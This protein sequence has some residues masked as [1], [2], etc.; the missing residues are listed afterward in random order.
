MPSASELRILSQ[1]S[2]QPDLNRFPNYVYE[3]GAG[4][5]S[6]IYHAE[7]GINGDHIDFQGRKGEWV[8]TPLSIRAGQNTKNQSPSSSNGHSTC[9]ASKASGNVYGAAK[10]ATLVVVKLPDWTA[11]AMQEILEVIVYHISTNKGG[12]RAVVNIS[13]GSLERYSDFSSIKKD[14]RQRE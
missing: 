10:D 9:T 7:M 5:D 1:P 4:E 6:F 12:S 11:A 8:F 3:D 13:W 14:L 2:G